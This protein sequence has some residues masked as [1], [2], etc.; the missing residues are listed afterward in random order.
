MRLGCVV[1]VERFPTGM[2]DSDPHNEDKQYK[3]ADHNEGD[4]PALERRAL[5]LLQNL[6]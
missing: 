4:L 3:D 1:H 5:V 6:E 2:L